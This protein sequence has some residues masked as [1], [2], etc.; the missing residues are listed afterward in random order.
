[1]T[2]DVFEYRVAKY[3]GAYAAA[4][5]GIDAV[6]F[7]AGLGENNGSVRKHVCAYLTYLGVEIDE[8]LNKCR[9]IERDLSKPSAKVRALVIPTNEELMIARETLKLL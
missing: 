5:N 4:M 2:M 1:I 3:I 8:E 9:S 7:T 6:V